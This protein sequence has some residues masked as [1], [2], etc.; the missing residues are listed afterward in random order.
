MSIDDPKSLPA[1]RKK[2]LCTGHDCYPPRPTKGCSPNVFYN[3]RGA[4]RLGDDLLGH[5]CIT[6]SKEKDKEKV[7]VSGCHT[8]KTTSGSGSVFI[9]S[10]SAVRVQDSVDCGSVMMTGS[11]NV[12]IGE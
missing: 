11:H 9:N 5:C 6:L 2:D 7:I 8:G 12:Y 3:S 4:H 1:V 10:L